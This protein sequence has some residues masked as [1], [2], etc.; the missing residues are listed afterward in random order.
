MKF[1]LYDLDYSLVILKFQK[2]QFK[3]LFKNQEVYLQ[4]NF[5]IFKTQAIVYYVIPFNL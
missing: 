4:I 2:E 5:N 1:K 3:M